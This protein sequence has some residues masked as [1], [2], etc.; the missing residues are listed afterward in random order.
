MPY[1]PPPVVRLQ[2]VAAALW[3]YRWRWIVPMLLVAAASSSYSELRTPK[4]EA[5]QALIIREGAT[6]DA[7][8]PGNFRDVNEMKTVQETI[9][10]LAKS[11]TVL[12]G[13]L[14]AIGPPRTRTGDEMGPWPNEK[15]LTDLRKQLSV[16]PP[17]GA[18]FCKTEVF[19]VKVKNRSKGR[20]KQIVAAICD[21]LE[22]RYQ[23]LLH[24]RSQSMVDELVRAEALSAKDLEVATAKLAKLES[25]VGVDL[26]ELRTLNS[27]STA[28][29][30]LRQTHI[31]VEN[32]IRAFAAEARSNARLLALLREAQNNPG[33]FLATPDSLLSSQ[34]A[35]R[36]LKEGLVA[37]QLKAATLRGS[38]LPNHPS[39]LGSEIAEQEIRDDIHRELTPAIQGLEVDQSMANG[40]QETLKK[41]LETDRRR[42]TKLASV[43]VEY[44]TLVAKV[45]NREQLLEESRGYVADA[46]A[47]LATSLSVSR[48]HRIGTP[49]T[50]I[51]PVGPRKALIILAGAL[52]GLAIGL[53][54]VL[55]TTESPI[56]APV[57]AEDLPLEINPPMI[58]VQPVPILTP[59]PTSPLPPT[60]SPRDKRSRR[61]TQTNVATTAGQP[62][63]TDLNLAQALQQIEQDDTPVLN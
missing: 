15:V 19:Y 20:S 45:S 63:G 25:S 43:R 21:Q 35:L 12:V 31:E 40:R 22:G 5:T 16:E 37:A 58:P 56:H 17:G 44:G 7:K 47:Q 18:E 48:I 52:G 49:E 55:L 51:Y 41:Q 59:Q 39:V 50:G 28:F 32:E 38:M 29:S 57:S 46:R 36:S 14:K 61:P 26:A 42:L 3:K 4:W 23:T 8:R 6:A 33:T 2:D 62:L 9:L 1:T 34:P 11:R 30:D 27:S 24:T 53:G 54:L 60:S 13:A 10:E